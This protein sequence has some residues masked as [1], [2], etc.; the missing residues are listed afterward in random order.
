M[1]MKTNLLILWTFLAACMATAQNSQNSWRWRNTATNQTVMDMQNASDGGAWVLLSATYPQIVKI[2]PSGQE[3]YRLVDST[4]VYN[5]PVNASHLELRPDGQG[6]AFLAQYKNHPTRDS[7]F[8]YETDWTGAIT[9]KHFIMTDDSLILSSMDADE[10]GGYLI[11]G[12]TGAGAT[13]V[14]Q[15]LIRFN[16]NN[17]NLSTIPTNGYR[18]S[19]KNA[20][21]TND[22]EIFYLANKTDSLHYA[23]FDTLGVKQ[24]D[25]TVYLLNSNWYYPR[26]SLGSNGELLS[27]TQ[28]GKLRQLDNNRQFLP[29][30]DFAAIGMQGTTTSAQGFD[31]NYWVVDTVF[32]AARFCRVSKI[33][34]ID[35]SVMG[36]TNFIGMY[37]PT[38]LDGF[39][40]GQISYLAP[41]TDGGVAVLMIDGVLK[42]NANGDL[43]YNNI[44]GDVLHDIDLSCDSTIG[45]SV[46]RQRLVKAEEI[47]TGDIY[48]NITDNQ[49][50]YR[51]NVPAGTYEVSSEHSWSPYNNFWITC[52][53]TQTIAFNNTAAANKDTVDILRQTTYNCPLLEVGH[54]TYS[55][56][57]CL[58]S[59][60]GLWVYNHGTIASAPN[61]SITFNLD[62]NQRYV[63]HSGGFNM[64]SLGNNEYR[65]DIG[66]VPAYQWVGFAVTVTTDCAVPN[67]AIL[68]SETHVY[69]DTLCGFNS[70]GA[71]IIITDSCVGTDSLIFSLTNIGANMAT[72]QNYSI[73]EDNLMYRPLTPFMLNN[74]QKLDIPINRKDS[75]D[76]I[77][78]V[79]QAA[80]YPNIQPNLPT[81]LLANDCN[82]NAVFTNPAQFFINNSF[83]THYDC[84]E[85]RIPVPCPHQAQPRG[86]GS[87]N[88]IN[89]GTPIIYQTGFSNPVRAPF[90]KVV[91]LDTLDENLDINT[92]RMQGVSH[93]FVVDMLPNRIL[94]FTA[95]NIGL[96][97]SSVSELASRGYI[98]YEIMPL[99]NLPLGTRIEHRSGVS[100]DNRPP[101]VT[102]TVFH[103]I[104]ENFIPLRIVAIEETQ[105]HT[106]VTAFPNPFAEELTFSVGTAQDELSIQI[107]DVM[108]KPV[109]VK[110][111]QTNPQTLQLQ[112][113]NLPAGVYFFQ[114]QS[115]GQP[116]ATG[117]I[118]A[119]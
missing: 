24:W 61:T 77:I 58:Q 111:A 30:I 86:Y 29:E 35:N 54:N 75:S 28:N 69:P 66:S 80:T 113:G 76:Y 64:T 72:P 53:N 71:N 81:S 114:I 63:A 3:E 93:Q 7:V 112:R 2:N 119:Q 16:R 41:T 65:F 39:S 59:V 106:T 18:I 34:R 51:I 117:K 6:L 17:A 102:E 84:V 118:I 4:E 23:I 38:G 14:R 104:G 25:T 90:N 68:C 20:V 48:Y 47:N 31:G 73:I 56:F 82:P 40:L 26:A 87:S 60:Y 33:S 52:N 62:P 37:N 91:I 11:N 109:V 98:S 36:A 101:V 46:L 45:D 107:T 105:N 110:F 88:L 55:V 50:K 8:L 95:D 12:L 9:N 108:G 74:G 116:L 67:G 1:R 79:E 13:T 94:R 27:F 15:L 22:N 103:T 85:S 57:S 44:Y 99:P 96:V 42:I 10:F 21:Y 97:D 32:S 115:K 49:G 43:Y 5:A 92:F 100:V 78:L 89:N 19:N 83:S 70:T